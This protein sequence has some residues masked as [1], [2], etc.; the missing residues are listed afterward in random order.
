MSTANAH[1]TRQ[2]TDDEF[3]SQVLQSEQPVLVDFY[4]DW[5][6]PCKV[7]APTI[8]QIA[9]QFA[10]RAA[11]GKLDVDANPQTAQTFAIRSIPTVLVFV[12]GQVTDRIV[13]VQPPQRYLEALQKAA[14]DS[15]A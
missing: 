4:A 7:L 2:F 12:G 1:T 6:P 13:G 11:V 14:G 8:E 9:E 10:G 15:A 5:C 3:E